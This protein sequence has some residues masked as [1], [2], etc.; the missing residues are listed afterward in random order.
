MPAGAEN[1][2]GHL[3]TR[4][5]SGESP[6]VETSVAEEW[7]P[8]VGYESIY[9]VSNLGRV[10]TMRP[11]RGRPVGHV[12]RLR[13]SFGYRR[14]LL[15]D[16]RRRLFAAV[17]RLVLQAFVGDPPAGQGIVDHINGV[18]HDNRVTNLRW[19]SYVENSRYAKE[20]CRKTVLVADSHVLPWVSIMGCFAP[21]KD[22]TQHGE[23][24]SQ[25]NDRQLKEQRRLSAC[26]AY[27]EL[28]RTAGNDAVDLVAGKYGVHPATVYRWLKGR[29][30]LVPSF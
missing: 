25:L 26:V 12:M 4:G 7:R 30:D 28:K 19:C 29:A 13:E 1:A 14:V 16:G 18:R 6:M 5:T 11:P 27:Q 17:H 10:R 3:A 15:W 23:S 8:V 2:H 24:E 9:E 20:R 22:P 21:G